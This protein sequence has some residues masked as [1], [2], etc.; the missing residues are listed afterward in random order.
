LV[1]VVRT[2]ATSEHTLQLLLEF[3]KKLGKTPI[4]TSDKPGFLVN[5]ILFPYLGE[6]V[7][8]V[9]SGFSIAQIDSEL[10]TF[11]MPMGPLELL[12]QVGIDIASH[13]ARSLMDILPDTQLPADFL[14][15][16]AG[17]GLLGKKSKLGFYD[18]RSGKQ[19]T[20]N[21]DI[22]HRPCSTTPYY[23]FLDDG[24]TNVQRRLVYAL[25]NEAVHCLDE[26][27]VAEPWMVDM[28]M[29][30][31]TGFAPMLGGPLR[32]IDSLGIATVRH[33]MSGLA[34]MYGERFKP[35]DGIE[36]LARNKS[37]FFGD[38]DSLAQTDAQG[39]VRSPY[40]PLAALDPPSGS[41]N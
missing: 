37:R 33:N 8:M 22:V 6:A 39:P 18:Y 2:E 17:R 41:V 25:L 31:G 40:P 23:E 35:A 7:R 16:M 30:L 4:V 36:R 12:D 1:E 34:Q 20:P 26:Q 10:R 24:L 28:G 11:G 27:V 32:L 19:P 38:V 21:S 9:S 13:V 5:R 15:D 14:A 3:V 29:V